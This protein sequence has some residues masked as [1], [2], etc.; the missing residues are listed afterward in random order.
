MAFHMHKAR[1]VNASRQ[2]FSCHFKPKINAD[3]IDLQYWMIKLINPKIKKSSEY[4]K[5]WFV[6]SAIYCH[7]LQ[8]VST[9]NEM[10]R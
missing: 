7:T 4:I 3:R 5:T 8:S 9:A 10:L 1:R 6:T 2:L